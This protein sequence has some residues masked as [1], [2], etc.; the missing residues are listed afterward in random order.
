MYGPAH[1]FGDALRPVH[2]YLP[3]GYGPVK[4]QEIYLLEGAAVRNAI[5]HLAD[6]RRHL[7]YCTIPATSAR[8]L[9][10]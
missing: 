9:A 4:G 3:L 1:E 2:L 6:W 8:L 5:A 10:D 7:D